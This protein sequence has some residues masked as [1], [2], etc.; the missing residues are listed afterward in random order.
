MWRISYGIQYR[1]RFCGMGGNGYD[2]RFCGMGG[3]GYDYRFCGILHLFLRCSEIGDFMFTDIPHDYCNEET[4]LPVKNHLPPELGARFK[5]R[6][7]WREWGYEPKPGEQGHRMHPSSL[8]YRSYVYF[9]ESEV[10]SYTGTEPADDV[11]YQT[12]VSKKTVALEEC[13]GHGGLAAIGWK[14]PRPYRAG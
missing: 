2:Y 4:G 3:N 8:A 5:T 13:T 7:Q 1:N 6:K 14:E 9:H 10:C 11:R 12:H